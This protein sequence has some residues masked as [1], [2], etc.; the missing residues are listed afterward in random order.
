MRRLFATSL[1]AILFGSSCA[2]GGEYVGQINDEL[3]S[4]ECK[5]KAIAISC[6]IKVAEYIAIFHISPQIRSYRSSP[7]IFCTLRLVCRE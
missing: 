5:C 7:V 2:F 6:S 3:L 4:H 1:F